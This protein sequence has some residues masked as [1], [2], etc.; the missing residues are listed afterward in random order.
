MMLI[1]LRTSALLVNAIN[2]L[3]L[4][5]KNSFFQ[6]CLFLVLSLHVDTHCI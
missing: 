2:G 4:L 3:N 6:S 5:N 1:M